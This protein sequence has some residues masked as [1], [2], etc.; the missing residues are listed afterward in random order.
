[1]FK[2]QMYKLTLDN[3]INDYR[4]GRLSGVIATVT[5]NLYTDRCIAHTV[6]NGKVTFRFEAT[7]RQMEKIVK[8]VETH[9]GGYLVRENF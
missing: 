5:G 8:Y 7:K 9:L 1:M 4:K 6:Y 3:D 2:K